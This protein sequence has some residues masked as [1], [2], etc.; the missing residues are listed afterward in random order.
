M[1]ALAN[2]LSNAAKFSPPDDRIEIAV[3]RRGTL[4]RVAV[5][6]HGPGIPDELRPEVFKKFSRAG[7]ANMKH[8]GGIGL[9]LSIARHIVGQH[10]G[11]I[12]YESQP[13]VRTTFFIDLPELPPEHPGISGAAPGG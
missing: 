12:D 11:R 13:G 7:A 9:G 4:I 10:G 8:K 3:S 2:L 1:Q 5:T 6:D